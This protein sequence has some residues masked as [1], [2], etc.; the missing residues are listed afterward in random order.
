MEECSTGLIRRL[1]WD[2]D[3]FS[4]EALADELFHVFS[5]TP[6]VDDLVPF[7]IVIRI[8]LLHFGK[9]RIVSDWSRTVDPYGIKDL[10]DGEP[11]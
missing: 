1:L 8:I 2:K 3:V 4:E 6:V 11:E 5:E 7:T 9:C 10:I